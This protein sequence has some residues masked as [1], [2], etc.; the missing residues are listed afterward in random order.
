ME[1][2]AA[3]DIRIL[4]FFFF[5]FLLCEPYGS[6]FCFHRQSVEDA[7]RQSSIPLAFFSP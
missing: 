6:V 1:T 5:F 2:F 3:I 7:R 4:S